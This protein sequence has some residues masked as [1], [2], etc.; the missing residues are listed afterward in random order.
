MQN[1]VWHCAH[2]P[3]LQSGTMTNQCNPLRN[4]WRTQSTVAY[5]GVLYFSPSCLY[6]SLVSSFSPNVLLLANFWLGVS[7]LLPGTAVLPVCDVEV[8]G[9]NAS[10]GLTALH[11]RDWYPI[12]RTARLGAQ[13]RYCICSSV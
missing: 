10:M 12:G 3:A 5:V 2:W 13:K 9:A 4:T 11:E 8:G 7:A 1:A 6:F